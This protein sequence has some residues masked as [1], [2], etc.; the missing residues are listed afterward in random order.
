MNATRLCLAVATAIAVAC[1]P[2]NAQRP[3]NYPGAPQQPGQPWQPQQ[4]QPQPLQQPQALPVPG[5][6][7]LEAMGPGWAQWRE[8][9]N[10]IWVR[11]PQAPPFAGFPVF[12]YRLQ[13]Y[14]A[15][16]LDRQRTEAGALPLP[17]GAPLEAGWPPWARTRDRPPLP[18]AADLAL[19][20]RHADRV[21]HRVA[22]DEPFVPAFF[23]DKLYT[24]PAGAEVDV[25]Q[26]GEF[27]LL[28][29]DSSRMF[30]RGP[31]FV[32]LAELTPTTV[33]LH[34]P[35]VTHLRFVASKREHTLVLPDSSMLRFGAAEA[36]DLPFE[37]QIERADE[38]G[39]LGGRATLSNLGQ[40]DV[41]WQYASGQ[42]TLP[43]G[44]RLTFFLTPPRDPAAGN[45]TVREGVAEP[46][47]DAM[48]CRSSGDG[49]VRWSGARFALPAGAQL[50]LDPIQGR[51]FAPP[52][53]PRK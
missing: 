49:D 36:G 7:S 1:G 33:R 3:G 11:T 52:A 2:V 35:R 6:T 46:A 42:V 24:L 29:H 47:G 8:P 10:P 14:G 9:L 38:P 26:S 50:R 30:A 19:L 45:L 25:R 15:Y 20:V 17:P 21:W 31:T 23:H 39:W 41:S 4:Q 34:L 44:H 12:P 53:D 13:G 32:T 48:V 37:V 43:P 18:F 16:P 51:P 5:R 40:S 27:E 22:I 28:L